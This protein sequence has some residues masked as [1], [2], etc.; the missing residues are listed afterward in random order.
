LRFYIHTHERYCGID[1]HA[2]SM[3]LCILDTPGEILPHRNFKA[4]PKS[5][6]AV[7]RSIELELPL[8]THYDRLLKALGQKLALAAKAHDAFAYHLLR[9]IPGVVH[10]VERLSPVDRRRPHGCKASAAISPR[11]HF[12]FAVLRATGGRATAGNE[13]SRA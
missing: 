13:C 1:L 6:L 3:H 5:F 2:R 9:S 4:E 11:T 8:I 7:R 12:C 10:T